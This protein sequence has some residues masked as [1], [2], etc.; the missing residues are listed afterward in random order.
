MLHLKSLSHFQLFG[1]LW[2]IQSM[3]FSSQNTGGGS[4]SLLQG[5]LCNNKMVTSQI[6]ASSHICQNP[7]KRNTAY[8]NENM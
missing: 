3:E 8:K 4:L 7:D 6:Y 2:T 5:I 1:T